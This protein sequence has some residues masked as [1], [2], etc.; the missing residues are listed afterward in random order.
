ME[1]HCVECHSAANMGTI[2]SGF[3]AGSYIQ[4]MR[5]TKQGAAVIPG[6][7]DTS[8]LY[9]IVSGSADPVIQMK[10]REISPTPEQTDTIRLWINQGAVSNDSK[11]SFQ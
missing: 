11:E 2:V 10:H 1:Q 7:A 8:P 4:I 3:D 9:L 6:S 5:G